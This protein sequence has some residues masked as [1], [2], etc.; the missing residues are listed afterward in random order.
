MRPTAEER[1]EANTKRREEYKA[2][3]EHLIKIANADE[4]AGVSDQ[5]RI[6]A[7]QIVLQIDQEGAPPAYKW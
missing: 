1:R 2:L 3:R 6:A 7:A 4:T 5:D